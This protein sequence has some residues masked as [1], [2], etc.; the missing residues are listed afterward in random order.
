MDSSWDGAA[1][2]RA[3]QQWLESWP[4]A[5]RSVLEALGVSGA[6]PAGA[7]PAGAR[8]PGIPPPGFE[9]PALGL[10]RE[11]QEAW[12][13]LSRSALRVTEAQRRLAESW[14]EILRRA[15]ASLG[16][17]VAR[18]AASGEP[19]RSVRG[20]YDQWI[21]AAEQAHAEIVHAHP[22]VELQAELANA[23]SALKIE[24]RA[25]LEQ[26]ARE[27]DLPTRT[28]LNTLL[29]RVKDLA[30]AVRALESRLPTAKARPARARTSRARK[31]K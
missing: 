9:L 27:Y 18:E 31:G 28:E 19:V 1:W 15:A 3:Q 7:M 10:T 5:A 17:R 29:L 12:D 4:E 22:Y 13:R 2:L 8:P 26:W 24:Q 11:R 30:S 25:F 21:D 20:L 23:T 16:A 6:V 14:T